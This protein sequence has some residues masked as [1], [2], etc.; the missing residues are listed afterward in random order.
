[1]DHFAPVNT[2]SGTPGIYRRSPLADTDIGQGKDQRKKE[3]PSSVIFVVVNTPS[4]Q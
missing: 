1:V 2:W 3:K 4:M